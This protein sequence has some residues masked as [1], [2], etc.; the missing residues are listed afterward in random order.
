MNTHSKHYLIHRTREHIEIFVEPGKKSAWDFIVRYKEPSKRMRTPKH[1]HIV[2]DLFAKRTG[3]RALTHQLIKHII[4]DIILSV[5]PVASYP[6]RLQVFSPKTIQ[7]FQ[8]LNAFGEYSVEFLLVVVE[9]LMLQEKTNYPDGTLNL[10][11]F[12][13]FLEDADIF[14]I[15]STATFRR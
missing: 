1:I 14:T 15:V 5:Q 13:H 4:S 12:Q 2:V 10:R 3:N 11:L 8:E 9:L 7:A 6:P